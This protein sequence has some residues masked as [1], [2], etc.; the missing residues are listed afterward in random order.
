MRAINIIWDTDYDEDEVLP[1]E[2]DI[3][4]GMTDIEEISDYLSNTTGYCHKGFD[5]IN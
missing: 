1:T 2:F 3:P 4:N 5:L